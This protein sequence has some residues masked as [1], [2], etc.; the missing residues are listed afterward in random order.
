VRL[1]SP[2]GTEILATG[3]TW[4]SLYAGLGYEIVGERVPARMRIV[5]VVHKY[6]PVHNAG[7]E[8]M[9]HAILR[10]LVARG[11]RATVVCGVQPA[12]VWSLD[13]VNVIAPANPARIPGLVRRADVVL[14][15]LD[16]THRAI[17]AASRHA[18]PLVHL[19]HND[20]QLRFHKVRS[21]DAALVVYNSRWLADRVRFPTR[22]LV[23]H[24]PVHVA[25]YATTPGR[26]VTLVNVTAAKGAQTWYAAARALPS[27]PFLGVQGAYGLQI[28]RNDSPNVRMIRN[29]ASIREDVYAETRVLL[30]PSLYESWGRVGIEAAC[31]GIP[32]IAHPTPGLLESLGDAGTFVDRD[33]PAAYVEA[34]R[35]LLGDDD[36]YREAGARARARAVELEARSEEQLDELEAALLQIGGKA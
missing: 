6:P 21:R 5:A 36:L 29:T 31:S 2:E 23:V 7:A 13:G 10:R 20:E 8:W 18:R 30:M 22:S 4:A 34:L 16:L 19:V 27:V 32:T 33:D 25:D 9:L 11:D 26:S 17:D 15:H 12:G 3:K 24:P 35:P 28:A 1:R 14:T